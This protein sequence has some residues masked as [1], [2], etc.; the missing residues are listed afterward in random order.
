MKKIVVIFTLI[1][2]LIVNSFISYSI[3]FNGDLWKSYNGEY[4]GEA[5]FVI[6]ANSNIVLFEK[7]A[8]KRMYPASLTKIMT[9]LVVLDNISSVEETL[10]FSYN[11]VTFNLDKTSTTIGASAG[12]KLSI[13][14]CLYSILL[15]SANDAANA[16]AEYVAGSINDFVLLM[17]EKAL[18]LGMTN[19]HFEN[20]TG[21]HHDNQYSTARDLG[22]MMNYAMKNELFAQIS[23]S[24]SYRHAPIRRYKNPNNSNNVLLNTN[25]MLAKGSGYYYRGII[26]GKTGYTSQSGYNLIE[27]AERDNLKIIFV[28]LNCKKMND[29]FVDA[30]NVFNFYFE[31]Y[32]SY[33]VKD[34]DY[35]FNNANEYNM[36]IDD[37]AL[38]EVL[39]ITVE[40]NAS[41]TVPKSIEFDQLDSIVSFEESNKNKTNAIGTITY[42]LYN[43]VVGVCDIVG[44][45]PYEEDNIFTSYLNIGQANA[46][47]NEGVDLN[48]NNPVNSDTPIYID[49]NGKIRISK[50]VTLVINVVL[51]MIF[52]YILFAYIKSLFI[53]N[54][55]KFWIKYVKKRKK[56]R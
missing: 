54:R 5:G 34:N 46:N 19:T 29:R 36:L 51:I 55:S 41:I 12:D 7:N 27:C 39:Q 11:S 43:D 45:N 26:A 13:K 53:N 8:D 4:L 15:P 23:S 3:D 33:L 44:T 1:F 38:V 14:D 56:A 28:D 47:K 40:D 49:H 24:V 17:N 9:A 37:I 10:V 31:N 20:P 21:L 22:I 6:D 2:S 30:K 16:L 18:N 50:P 32:K 35:R 25:S 48:E 52:T 42:K